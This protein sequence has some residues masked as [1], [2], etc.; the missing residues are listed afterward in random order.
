M[1]IKIMCLTSVSADSD[2]KNLV[3]DFLKLSAYI[4]ELKRLKLT[5]K[6]IQPKVLLSQGIEFVLTTERKTLPKEQDLAELKRLFKTSVKVFDTFVL[7]R[8]KLEFISLAVVNVESLKSTV[9]KLLTKFTKEQGKTNKNSVEELLRKA[10]ETKQ[11]EIAEIDKSNQDLIYKKLELERDIRAKRSKID[12]LDSSN[13]LLLKGI[14]HRDAFFKV[15]ERVNEYIA[16]SVVKTDQLTAFMDFVNKKAD[17]VFSKSGLDRAQAWIDLVESANREFNIDILHRDV[18]VE[19][20]NR[21]SSPATVLPFK[22][23]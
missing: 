2:I 8:T 17:S 21:R 14:A 7:G 19:L 9:R 18:V 22:Q 13:A 11:A 12:K 1:K 15:V 5:G 6:F 10:K 23:R 4:P 20:Q 16:A 3:A